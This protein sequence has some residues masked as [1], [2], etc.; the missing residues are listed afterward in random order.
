MVDVLCDGHE[1]VEFPGKRVLHGPT[2]G[3][4]CTFSAAL[5]AALT[6]DL[7]LTEAIQAAKSYTSS[8]IRKSISI[9]HG[10]KLPVHF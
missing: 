7:P 9:G 6:E 4:G 3:T 5:T 2:R 10:C 1:V 8:V